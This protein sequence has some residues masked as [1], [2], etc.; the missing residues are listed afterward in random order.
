MFTVPVFLSLYVIV[1]PTGRW[2]PFV[3][4]HVVLLLL[5]TGA[6]Y[7]LWGAGVTLAADGIREREYFSRM[8][9][10][11]VEA[12]ASV[13]VMS[14]RNSYSDDVVEHVFFLDADGRTLLRFRSQMW[15]RADLSDMINFYAVPIHR[16][17]TP[18]SWSQ[19]RRSHGRNLDVWERHPI[20]TSSAVT[21]LLLIV[22]VPL[23]IGTL[24][25][26]Q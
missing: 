19:L 25:V 23:V 11:P 26:I 20:V 21:L 12:V 16:N 1:M 3:I 22:L 4:A 14:V 2:L 10:T 15:D 7:R 5:F 24:A 18:L 6:A 17:E 9:F 8:V 13:D